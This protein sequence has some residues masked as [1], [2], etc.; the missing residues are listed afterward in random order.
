MGN[1]DDADDLTQETFVKLYQALPR[2]RPGHVRGWVYRVATN[3]CLDE[4]RHRSLV[5]WL[6]WEA[7]FAAALEDRVARDDPERDALQEETRHE[8][9]EVLNR[10]PPRYRAA[11]VLR[12]YHGLGYEE[13]ATALRTTRLAVKTLL[14][15]ARARF[16]RDWFGTHG[17]PPFPLP[18]RP[19]RVANATA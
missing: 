11:L 1:L 13:I 10:L 9:S 3:A 12:E 8:V 15:R 7:H 6:P 4:L 16:R 18:P 2:F 5:G 17:H 19:V 14:L